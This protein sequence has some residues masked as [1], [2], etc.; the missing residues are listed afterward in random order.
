MMVEID[1][2]AIGQ[3]RDYGNTNSVRTQGF[4]FYYVI[5]IYI[6]EKNP[7]SCLLDKAVTTNT[8]TPCLYNVSCHCQEVYFV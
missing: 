4:I 5:F 3:S 1:N 2:G 8:V 7:I 6:S